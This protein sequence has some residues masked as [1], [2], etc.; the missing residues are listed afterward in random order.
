VSPPPGPILGGGNFFSLYYS[1]S[2]ISS[3]YP[4]NKKIKKD[5]KHYG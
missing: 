4:G 1:D 2:R 5:V 3:K